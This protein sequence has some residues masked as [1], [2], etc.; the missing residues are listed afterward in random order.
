MRAIRNV[1]LLL[2]L[3]V[4]FGT[5]FLFKNEIYTLLHGGTVTV[6]LPDFEKFDFNSFINSVKKEVLS[7]EPLRVLRN[8]AGTDLTRAGIISET[9]KQR[10]ANGLKALKENTVLNQVAMAKAIDI[11]T[12]QYFDHI[13]PSGVGPDGLAKK[14]G[15]DY[16][17]IGE[18]LIL[19]IFSGDKEAVDDWMNS[20]GH[21][22]NILNSR[23][24][25][26]GVGVM[27]GI[28]ENQ[29]V[30]VGVQEFGLPASVCPSPS[31]ALKKQIENMQ[32]QLNVISNNIATLRQEIDSMSPK[33]GSE[34]ESAVNQYNDLIDQY[35]NLANQ[36]KSLIND[37][38]GQ[39]NQFNTCVNAG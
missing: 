14:Y 34:Y 4:V 37:Y 9:N 29:T 16:I 25:E 38:N 5:A 15:Y 31:A 39:V 20:P 22:A 18:N 23:Y 36:I 32:S 7:P 35:N 26:I 21:R 33:R 28:F 8:Q 19:G 24:T 11:F 3:I 12:K 27:K 30:W 1:L 10:V 6:N 13:S 2:L 17:V